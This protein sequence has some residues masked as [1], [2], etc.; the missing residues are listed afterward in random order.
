MVHKDLPAAFDV[1]KDR[2]VLVEKSRKLL[3]LDLVE[4]NLSVMRKVRC[5]LCFNSYS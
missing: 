4:K 1:I 5:D 3:G 2:K